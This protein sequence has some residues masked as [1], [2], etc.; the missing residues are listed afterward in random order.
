MIRNFYQSMWDP[1]K[2]KKG[3]LPMNRPLPKELYPNSVPACTL[4]LYLSAFGEGT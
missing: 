2:K 3:R 1:S 4:L